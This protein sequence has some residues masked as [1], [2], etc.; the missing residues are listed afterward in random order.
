MTLV[1]LF[2]VTTSFN[3]YVGRLSPE[4]TLLMADS[5]T[6]QESTDWTNLL[7]DPDLVSH[8]AALLKTY[9]EAAPEK[10]EAALIAAMRQIKQQAATAKTSEAASEL[11]SGQPGSAP[12]LSD[13][14]EAETAFT[15]PVPLPVPTP[16]PFE[17]DIFTPSWGQDRRKYPRIK[18]F[19]AVELRVK[20]VPTPIWGN[21]ANTSLG[22]CYVDS[23]TPIGSGSEV[24]IGLWMSSGKIW[25]K[26]LV[27]NGVVTKAAPAFGVRVKFSQLQANER[28]ALREF[29]KFVE[30]ST[31][32]Y[33]KQNGYLAQ[34]KR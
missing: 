2:V 10:R 14:S 16:P 23:L 28:D 1:I 21:L 27:L 18:C 4:S 7:A 17:P 32:G 33:E 20:G 15:M 29:L 9:R 11:T 12:S 22:G 31:K 5:K 24:E 30:S 25:V 34:L 8:L 19:V 26:G 3:L 13:P 6:K